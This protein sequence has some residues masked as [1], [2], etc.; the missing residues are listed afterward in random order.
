MAEWILLPPTIITAPGT[1]VGPELGNLTDME[2]LLVEAVFTYGAGG[3]TVTA[4][5]QTSLQGTSWTDIMAIQFATTS[6][7][8]LLSVRTVGILSTPVTPADGGLA[9]NTEVDGLLGDRLRVKYTSVG[10][11]SGGTQVAVYGVAKGATSRW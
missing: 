6:A 5:V 10:T 11:Y 9:I 3:T 1:A 7:R 2:S 4:Y 8:R